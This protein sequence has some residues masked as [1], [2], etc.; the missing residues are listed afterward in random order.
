MFAALGIGI[1]FLGSYATTFNG[2]WA[3]WIIGYGIG[4][5][6]T[7]MG[8]V[9]HGWLWMPDRPGLVSGIILAGVGL[10]GLIFDNIS[11]CKNNS[12]IKLNVVL[13][14]PDHINSLEGGVYPESVFSRVPYMI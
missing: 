4:G 13:V 2:W 11:M 10:S 3:T 7:Y 5:G 9:H 12:D 8:P 14:N 6:V 1:I